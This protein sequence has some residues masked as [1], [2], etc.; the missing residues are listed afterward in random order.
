M[1]ARSSLSPSKVSEEV[2]EEFQDSYRRA[3][4][5][6]TAMADVIPM[7]TGV[8]DRHF[9]TTGDIPFSNLQRFDSELS[10]PKPDKYFG[11]GPDQIA[12]RVR[13]DLE[14]YMIPS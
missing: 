1:E 7:I 14:Q 4:F 3:K 8:K 6:S 2:F 5:E 13:K 11:S 10:V 9:E 12:E